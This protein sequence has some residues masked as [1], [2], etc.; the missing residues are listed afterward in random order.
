MVPSPFRE[1]IPSRERL[2]R[3]K[4]RTI[5]RRQHALRLQVEPAGTSV[6]HRILVT[7][8]ASTDGSC[9]GI[10]VASRRSFKSVCPAGHADSRP[11]LVALDLQSSAVYTNGNASVYC[12]SNTTYWLLIN[13]ALR[14][15]SPELCSCTTHRCCASSADAIRYAKF[16]QR[17]HQQKRVV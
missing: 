10:A 7:S 4:A 15:Y 11:A 2:N 5:A 13:N 9:G 17:R 3:K 1:R 16:K 12:C 14:F 8:S 6:H